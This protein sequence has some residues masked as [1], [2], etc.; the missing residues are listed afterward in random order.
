[1]NKI[2]TY[3]FDQRRAF[4]ETKLLRKLL[5]LFAFYKCIYWIWDYKLLFAE[6]SMVYKHASVIPIW[7]KPAFLLYTSYSN[8]LPMLFLGL[9]TAMSLYLLFSEKAFRL[10]FFLLWISI[11]N[12]I[13]NTYCA[14]SAGDKLF[15]NLLFFCIFL[16]DGN[17]KG[18]PFLNSLDMAFHNSG[19]I[20]LRFQVCLV[21]LFAAIAK[22]PNEDWMDGN[23]VNMTLAVHDYSLPIAYEGYGTIGKVLN[24][25]VIWYQ[26]LFPVLVWIRP[27]KKWYL[28]VGILQ[29]LFIAFVLGL[30]SFGLIMIVAY[31]IFYAPISKTQKTS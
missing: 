12:I 28:L 16:A 21:Y 17:S 29:H 30:P 7:Q 15:E 13:N 5:A 25:L 10:V 2:V 31:A 19:L 11:V 8:V 9:A 6:H 26:F 24:Y 22:L 3:F 20:A 27:I 4:E 14:S 18:T 23:A 1:L